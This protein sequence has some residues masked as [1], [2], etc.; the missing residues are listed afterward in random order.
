MRQ[1]K[2]GVRRNG[3]AVVAVQKDGA[4]RWPSTKSGSRADALSA[5][6]RNPAPGRN[7]LRNGSRRDL[8]DPALA[9]RGARIEKDRAG[10][11][12]NRNASDIRNQPIRQIT[13]LNWG[14]PDRDLTCKTVSKLLICMVN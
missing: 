3:H 9:R 13:V 14:L 8:N 7:F 4:G 11:S 2:T 5:D 1:F 12:D 6:D 10:E